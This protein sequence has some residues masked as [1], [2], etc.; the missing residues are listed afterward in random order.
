MLESDNL[1]E[2]Y[3]T[4]GKSTHATNINNTILIFHASRTNFGDDGGNEGCRRV[5]QMAILF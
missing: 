1:R 3:K 4:I 5:D 2:D